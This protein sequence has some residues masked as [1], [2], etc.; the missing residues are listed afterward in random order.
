M[1][2]GFPPK[3]K[4]TDKN[5]PDTDDSGATKSMVSKGSGGIPASLKV[6]NAGVREASR[7]AKSFV[8]GALNIKTDSDKTTGYF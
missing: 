2:A 4:N 8:E 3:V 7:P 1:A 6:K 5:I